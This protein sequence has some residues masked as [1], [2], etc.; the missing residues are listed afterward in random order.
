MILTFSSHPIPSLHAFLPP[1]PTLSISIPVQNRHPHIIQINQMQP[2]QTT[3]KHEPQHRTP[4]TGRL[5]VPPRRRPPAHLPLRH[6]HRNAH[7]PL[8]SQR[9]RI[10]GVESAGAA[11]EVRERV[12]DVDGVVCA[13]AEGEGLREGEGGGGRGAGGE[14][15]GVEGGGVGDGCAGRSEGAAGG[16]EAV[17]CGAEDVGDGPGGE[18]RCE[19]GAGEGGSGGGAGRGCGCF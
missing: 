16:L 18:V 3:R 13:G 19:G 15:G 9:V 14:Q 1:I 2:A 6:R 5:E 12:V 17:G 11:A 10:R 7:A 4:G 8:R